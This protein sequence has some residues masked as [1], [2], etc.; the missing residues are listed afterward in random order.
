[1]SK[2]QSRAFAHADRHVNSE[3]RVGKG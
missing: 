3:T 2:G 1:V